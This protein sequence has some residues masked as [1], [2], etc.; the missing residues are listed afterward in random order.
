MKTS[1]STNYLSI[2][3]FKCAHTPIHEFPSSPPLIKQ[4]VH[5]NHIHPSRT[6]F[7]TL[8]CMQEIHYSLQSKSQP[9]LHFV[10]QNPVI[11]HEMTKWCDESP[12]PCSDEVCCNAWEAYDL[13]RRTL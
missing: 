5:T 1:Q 4:N 13:F 8:T 2:F 11:Q 6:E 9:K 7:S 12:R 3:P 10:N